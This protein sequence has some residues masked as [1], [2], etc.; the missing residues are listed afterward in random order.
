V[1][2]PELGIDIDLD[3]AE[4]D[5]A[6]IAADN[7]AALAEIPTPASDQAAPVTLT[8]LGPITLATADGPV[9][10]GVRTGSYA[11][12][13]LLAAH[14]AGRTLSQFAA[15]LHPDTDKQVAAQRIRTDV[16]AVRTIL[17]KAT[18]ITGRGV[19]ITYDNAAE[20]YRL[21]PDLIR[22]DL[23]QMLAAID[24]ANKAG[25]DDATAALAALREAAALYGG[26]FAA[27]QDWAVD[28]ATIYRHQ[29][30]NVYARIA[31][32]LEP[33]QPD[34]AVAALEKAIAYDPVNEEL[35]QRIMRIHGRQGR[36]DAVRRTLRLLENRYADLGE[37]EI[38]EATRQVAHRQLDTNP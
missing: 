29:I 38:S 35:Y 16:N 37:A 30:L 32:L 26:D 9:A 11:V 3:A 31:E 23:W 20:R 6:A 2:R 34:Q 15:T 27:D 21:D 33:D 5:P 14:P 36:P 28:Y 13:A 24:R 22:V 25:H 8:V 10:H 19:F 18:G 17:R 7:A 1:P 12:L 4:T